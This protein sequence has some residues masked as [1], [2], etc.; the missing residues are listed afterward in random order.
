[1]N[2]PQQSASDLHVWNGNDRCGQNAYAKNAHTQTARHVGAWVSSNTQDL[3]RVLFV[4]FDRVPVKFSVC[5]H[6]LPKQFFPL[7]SDR[8]I[9]QSM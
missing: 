9:L 4:K 2:A 3:P 5:S 7:L 8:P 1:M 6:S